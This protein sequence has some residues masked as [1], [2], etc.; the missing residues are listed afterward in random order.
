MAKAETLTL[1]S[2]AGLFN[3][4]SLYL[5]GYAWLFGMYSVNAGV[6]AFKTLP[7][8]QFGALQHKTFPIY[9]VLSIGLS[10]GLLALWTLSHPDVLGNLLRPQVADVAQV[11]ALGSVLAAQ[12]LNYF[13]VGPLTSKTM[14]QRQKL[15]KEEGKAYN[16]AGVSAEMKKLNSKFGQLHGISSLANL[17]AV[18]ALGFHGLWIGNAGVKGY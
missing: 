4:S 12:G 1:V 3:P 9:F 13:V 18:I 6:I 17:S 10:S 2:L 15:E 8:H 7:R 11:Y 5:V 16:E 14:F